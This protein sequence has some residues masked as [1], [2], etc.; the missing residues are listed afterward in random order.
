MNTLSKIISLAGLLLL[1]ACAH[2]PGQYGYYPDSASYG[3]GYTVTQRNYYG[4]SPAYYKGYTS[5]REYFPSPHHDHYQD[6]KSWGHDY[7]RPRHQHEGYGDHPRINSYPKLDHSL[8]KPGR[9]WKDDSEHRRHD[10]MRNWG[11]RQF[12]HNRKNQS[13]K[14]DRYDRKFHD[15][16]HDEKRRAENYE[17]SNRWRAHRH[18]QERA[19]SDRRAKSDNREN[20]RGWAARPRFSE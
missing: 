11:D 10:D 16:G 8:R 7:L 20:R 4:G 5:R 2:H 15:H 9:D 17:Q 14:Q 12:D 19:D 13:R 18:D 3:G 1:S 6:H